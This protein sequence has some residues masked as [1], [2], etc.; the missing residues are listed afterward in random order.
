MQNMQL[1]KAMTEKEIPLSKPP[2]LFN[3]RASVVLDTIHV[4]MADFFINLCFAAIN[5]I[6]SSSHRQTTTKKGLSGNEVEAA[7]WKVAEVN[8]IRMKPEVLIAFFLIYLT[9]KLF[10]STN[11]S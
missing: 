2:Q 4:I 7:G 3:G 10:I 1:R 8:T 6:K 9:V 11:P 5:K